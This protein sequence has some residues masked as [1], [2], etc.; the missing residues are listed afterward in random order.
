MNEREHNFDRQT[1]RQTGRIDFI[2]IFRAFG[3]ILMIMGHIGFGNK[4]DYFI[5][6]F[7]MPMF[8]LVSGF[9]YK[10]KTISFRYYVISKSK[11]LLIPYIVFGIFHFA[12]NC[13]L[14][15]SFSFS[16]LRALLLFPT[17]GDMPIA[18][19]LWFL[20]ALFVADIVFFGVE[21]IKNKRLKC[22]IVIIIT[23]VGQVSPALLGIELPFSV[24]PAFVGIGLMYIGKILHRYSTNINL[25]RI[26]QLFFFGVLVAVSIF[27]S[28]YVNMRKAMYPNE[29]ILFWINAVAASIIGIILANKTK[30]ILKDNTICKIL[31]SIGKNSIVY[32]CL[33]ELVIIL[34]QPI[35][36]RGLKH[37]SIPIN[38]YVSFF[39]SFVI[40]ICSIILLYFLAFLFEKTPLRVLLGRF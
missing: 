32:V 17:S 3:I 23:L 26:Y 16:A 15:K 30:E 7:H 10:Q 37:F 27:Q 38:S 20:I 25:V 18:G 14:S 40:L 34:L 5:H 4:F 28:E 12:I 33:N 22:I 29:F 2:D 6:A 19:A 24:S 8:F 21:R 9:L 36:Y 1:D 39:A 11:S 35:V 31:Q 13:F